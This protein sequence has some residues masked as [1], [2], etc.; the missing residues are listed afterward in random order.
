MDQVEFLNNIFLKFDLKAECQSMDLYPS[1]QTFNIKLKSKTKIKHIESILDEIWLEMKMSSKPTLSFQ[2]ETGLV[3]LSSFYK[4]KDNLKL[5]DI[6]S[7]YEIPTG[8]LLCLLGESP[9][10]KPIWMD[11][12][13]NPH[14]IIAGATG[15]GKS[16][17]LHNIIGNLL[18]YSNV[19]IHLMDPKN[20]EFFDY[21][22][23]D[24][25]ISVSYSFEECLKKIRD[26]NLEMERRY[27]L[28]RTQNITRDCFP[29]EILIIDE[30]AN[31]IIQEEDKVFTKILN[32][33]AQKSRAAG[34]H[35][36][37]STQR[38][39]VDIISGNIKANFPT[40]IA[41]R[42]SSNI[43]S[44]IILGKNGAEKL[45]GQGD[46]II[47]SEIFDM[48]RFQIAYISSQD[49]INLYER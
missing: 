46:A 48:Q 20:I 22:I 36:I 10:G 42:V 23:F 4:R 43:D 17:L 24:K 27:L 33:L 45:W 11:L 35:I 19:N 29:Y 15:S 7:K 9:E 44:R 34:I 21:E 41:C 8:N 26:L 39:S 16:G 25:K 38:P 40:R 30:F 37:I 14:M 49:I 31:L 3:Q 6:G 32:N 2:Q 1:M 12:V 5:L 28:M 13:K 18:L 47:S